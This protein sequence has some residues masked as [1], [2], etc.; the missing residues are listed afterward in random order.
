MDLQTQIITLIFS[1]FYGIFFSLF[2]SVNQK[3]IYHDKK[4][5][6][7]LGTFLVILISVLVYF[8]LLK[9]INF[10]AFHPYC[11]LVLGLGFYLEKRIAK[12]TRKW[13]TLFKVV[14]K[15]MAKKKITKTA[16]RRLTVLT[17]I[18]F[19]AIGYCAFTL[20]T[21]VISI[22]KLHNE[23]T[24]LKEELKNL[25]GNSE[26]LKTEIE[27]L[28]DK[29]YVAR[30]ARENYLYT[31]DGEYV[32][33][34]DE[35]DTKQT[36]KKFEITDEQIIYG[37]VTLFALIFFYIILKHRKRKKEKKSKPVKK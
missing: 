2:I 27:K 23:E 24:E 31:R 21:T 12:H 26:E 36:E 20:I 9:K 34:V 14:V 37:S 32:I 25:K 7:L 1:F 28:Q 35:T 17:P 22:Y 3:I 10:A 33:K 5:I 11:L 18:V 6:K 13:Y 29:D 15:K 4:W 16:K 8:I 30:Y 19:L